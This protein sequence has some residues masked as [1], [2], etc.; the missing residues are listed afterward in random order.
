M[1]DKPEIAPEEFKEWQD[2]K[3][4]KAL[5]YLLNNEI[6]NLRD[7]VENEQAYSGYVE[8]TLGIIAGYRNCNSAIEGGLLEDLKY[9]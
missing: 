6:S 8:R 5:V 9:E 7:R 2:N 4:T 3:V 1:Q